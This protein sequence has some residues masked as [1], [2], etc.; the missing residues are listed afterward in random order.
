MANTNAPRTK[1]QCLAVRWAQEE[2]FE[3]RPAPRPEAGRRPWTRGALL[4]HLSEGDTT[5]IVRYL[6]PPN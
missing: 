4:I 6:P 3:L 1:K 2:S 5:R